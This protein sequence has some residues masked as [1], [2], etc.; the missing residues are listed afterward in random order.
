MYFIQTDGF[1]RL[2][3]NKIKQMKK[4]SIQ[5]LI[6]VLIFTFPA[7]LVA[8]QPTW[9]DYAKRNSMYPQSEFITGFVSGHNSQDE[10][11]GKL[12]DKYEEMA[13][14]KVVQSNMIKKIEVISSG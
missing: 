5:S 8:Q 6:F 10:D 2:F 3:L 4:Y 14:A 9:V 13:K 1:T 7:G 12:M 11:P